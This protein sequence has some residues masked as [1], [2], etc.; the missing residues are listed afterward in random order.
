MTVES[1][2]FYVAFA[3]L[4]LALYNLWFVRNLES[5]QRELERRAE[6]LEKR[7]RTEEHQ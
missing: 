1:F 3:S 5:V 7:I 4:V 2:T 6:V